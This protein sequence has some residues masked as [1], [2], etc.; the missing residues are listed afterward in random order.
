MNGLWVMTVAGLI[1][2]EL[3]VLGKSP[4]PSGALNPCL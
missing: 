4:N 1:L 2:S 3:R